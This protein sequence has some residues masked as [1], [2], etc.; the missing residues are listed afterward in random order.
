[1]V[2]EIHDLVRS[3][4]KMVKTIAFGKASVDAGVSQ[5]ANTTSHAHL[6][7]SIAHGRN[8]NSVR[9][10]VQDS[11]VALCQDSAAH[12]VS[13]QSIPAKN[14]M[15]IGVVSRTQFLVRRLLMPN[16]PTV[17]PRGASSHRLRLR[18]TLKSQRD[19]FAHLPK[20]IVAKIAEK[21]SKGV[22]LG[23]TAGV[24]SDRLTSASRT[25]NKASGV[26]CR[27]QWNA[28]IA[29]TRACG[30]GAFT[31]GNVNRTEHHGVVAKRNMSQAQL[32]ALEKN[33]PKHPIAKKILKDV[34]YWASAKKGSKM[35]GNAETVEEYGR[36]P[37]IHQHVKKLQLMAS[38][39]V[40]SRVNSILK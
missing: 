20:Q 37:Q 15:A 4:H 7:P 11:K 39:I 16:G 12:L 33:R 3:A 21:D 2:R 25:L 34:S 28:Q 17:W 31:R 9:I 27:I 18:A 30:I 6:A 26:V 8:Q 1:M 5:H 36:D 22:C 10:V 19:C 32:C 14:R 38:L 24:D 13:Q 40:F 29:L 23:A 35:L